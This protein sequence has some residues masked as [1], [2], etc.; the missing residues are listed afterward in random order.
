MPIFEFECLDCGALTE[1]LVEINE[2]GLV[3]CS[4]CGGKNLKKLISAHA[5]LRSNGLPSDPADRCCA[6]TGPHSG[7]SGPGSCCGKS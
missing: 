1:I 3:S 4:Q 2:T 6:S 7:C 5:P